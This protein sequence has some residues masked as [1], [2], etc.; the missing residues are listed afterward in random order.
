VQG[1]A[2]M[3]KHVQVQVIILEKPVKLLK[4]QQR[5]DAIHKKVATQ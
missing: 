5:A 4:N 1:G 2:N 3:T